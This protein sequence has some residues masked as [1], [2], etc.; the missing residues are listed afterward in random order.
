[1]LW[2]SGAPT[3]EALAGTI[4]LEQNKRYDLTEKY[5]VVAKYVHKVQRLYAVT[6]MY[7]IVVRIYGPG[8]FTY[9]QRS[10]GFIAS[11]LTITTSITIS[12]L[13]SH[14]EA[15]IYTESDTSLLDH[16]F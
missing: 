12:L 5:A 7:A 9:K 2:I 10:S 11:H 13:R 3:A 6:I 16:S 14:I 15:A 4:V 8:A 1:M